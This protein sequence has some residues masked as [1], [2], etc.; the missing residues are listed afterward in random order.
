MPTISSRFRLFDL[1]GPGCVFNSRV[2]DNA[3]KWVFEIPAIADSSTGNQL[4]ILGGMHVLCSAGVATDAGLTLLRE[5]GFEMEAELVIYTDAGDRQIKMRKL[6]AQGLIFIDQHVQPDASLHP[7]VSWVDPSLL[8]SLNNKRNLSKWVPAEYLPTREVCELASLSRIALQPKRFPLVI[9]AVTEASCG[10]GYGVRICHN[11]SEIDEARHYFSSCDSVIVEDYLAMHKNLCVNYA[12]FADGRIEYLG[13]AQ[14]I[15]ND[16]LHYLG[17]WLEPPGG[18][19]SRLIEVGYEIMHKAYQHGYRGF[20]GF[21]AAVRED[22]SFHIYDLN[23]RFNGSTAPLLLYD[24]L[25]KHT[26]LPIARNASWKCKS[27][28]DDM[29]KSLRQAVEKCQLIPINT[30]DPTVCNENYNP[31]PQVKALLFGASKEDIN[32]KE[33]EL[34]SLGFY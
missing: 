8:S 27:S 29:I 28:F 22:G 7:G 24:A 34:A 31:E 26:G 4:T 13:A 19:T 3:A 32:E 6:A 15:I 21:D 5:I 30:F 9:K 23:F 10:G 25:A 20:A 11:E 33:R 2:P 16:K 17:N 1:C 12:V 18:Q 14:Q